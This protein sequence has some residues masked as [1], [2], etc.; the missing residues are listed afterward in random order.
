MIYSILKILCRLTLHSYFRRFRITGKENIPAEGPYIFVANHP[1][2]FMDPIVIGA[3]VKPQLYFI[4]AGEYIGS[5]F[6]AWFFKKA[7]H[8]IPVYR[9]STRPED[10]HK[11]KHMF[12]QCYDHLLK[13]GSLLVF[14]E[15]VS[16]TERNIKPLKTGVARIARGAVKKNPASCI[17]VVPVGLN[18]SNPHEFRSDLFVNIGK[19]IEIN[20]QVLDN[21]ADEIEKVRELTTEIENAMI[22]SVVHVRNE[23]EKVL[24]FLNEVYSRDLKKELGIQYIEQERE[25]KMHKDMIAIME[26][27]QKHDSSR[28][29]RVTRK[30]TH[31]LSLLE[32]AGIRDKGIAEQSSWTLMRSINLLLGLPLFITGMI[33]NAIPYYLVRTI[34]KRLK[35]KGT[36]L[37]SII[38][39][40]GLFIYL[41]WYTLVT[42][43]LFALTPL[44]WYSL[45][46]PIVLYTTGIYFL[47]YKRAL[48]YRSERIAFRRI[49]Q[50]DRETFDHLS[51]LRQEL[52]DELDAARTEYDQQTAG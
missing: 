20:Q 9:P 5:G 43:L 21:E 48:F 2:A 37:G 12:D 38:L 33:L 18:Y 46:A 45:L 31:Y 6:K 27:Y 34:V 1:S 36:F 8:M 49:M 15:G 3:V 42:I 14:P 11:N 35:I 32:D 44:D 47:V 29:L 30:L 10:V 41:F 4:A 51:Q 50:S 13:G 22:D 23:D 39:A 17:K 16:V 24:D 52:I 40:A 26:Y 19:A 7:L 25:F 28:Y